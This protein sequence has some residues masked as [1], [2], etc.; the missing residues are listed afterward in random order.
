MMMLSNK[1]YPCV[2]VALNNWLDI[3]GFGCAR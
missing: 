3:F 2:G 1:K